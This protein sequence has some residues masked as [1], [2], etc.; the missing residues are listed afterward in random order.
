MYTVTF[1]KLNFYA[2]RGH[3]HNKIFD[4]KFGLAK[5]YKFGDKL[6]VVFGVKLGG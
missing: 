5:N 2:T 3:S 4:L 6:V 1:E